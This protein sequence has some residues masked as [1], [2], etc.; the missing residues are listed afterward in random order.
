MSITQSKFPLSTVSNMV[1]G[2]S[3]QSLSKPMNDLIDDVLRE[4]NPDFEQTETSIKN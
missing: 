1:V 3:S 4:L 2:T